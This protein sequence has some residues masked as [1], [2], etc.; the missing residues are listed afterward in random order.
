MV[1]QHA[2]Q[3]LLQLLVHILLSLLGCQATKVDGTAMFLDTPSEL[4]AIKRQE[5]MFVIYFHPSVLQSLVVY[6]HVLVPV[7]HFICMR[8]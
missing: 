8:I 6:P 1:F 7:L 2:R 5:E 3:S 4:E